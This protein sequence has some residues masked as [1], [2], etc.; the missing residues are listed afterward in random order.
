MGGKTP[1]TGDRVV[2]KV[3]GV[4]D[5]E[6][7]DIERGECIIGDIESSKSWERT[8]ESFIDGPELVV[9]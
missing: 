5:G 2:V 8:W 3:Q 1:D 7:I 6:I 4:Q 9:A